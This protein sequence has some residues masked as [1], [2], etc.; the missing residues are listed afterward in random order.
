MSE[1]N[2]VILSIAVT[3]NNG[4]LPLFPIVILKLTLSLPS[5][6]VSLNFLLTFNI[7]S[8]IVTGLDLA[9]AEPL[10]FQ[11]KLALLILDTPIVLEELFNTK[12]VMLIVK[13][14]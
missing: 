1:V 2:L 11:F 6:L 10:L 7:G 4:V 12:T 5:I 14:P 8:T 13:L 9:K 3:L